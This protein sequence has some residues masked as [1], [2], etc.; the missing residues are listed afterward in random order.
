[1]LT[2]ARDPD[3]RDL[4]VTAL[5]SGVPVVHAVLNSLLSPSKVTNVVAT[6]PDPWPGRLARTISA[7][8]IER[9]S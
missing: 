1:M 7:A 4:L 2:S 3:G 6:K 8:S 5:H 9:V